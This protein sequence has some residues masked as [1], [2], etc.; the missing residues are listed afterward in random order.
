MVFFPSRLA[1]ANPWGGV[2]QEGVYPSFNAWD[3]KWCDPA[4]ESSGRSWF[5]GI[6]A[7]TDT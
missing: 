2:E 4:E 1:L 6:F 5:F 3:A 7:M